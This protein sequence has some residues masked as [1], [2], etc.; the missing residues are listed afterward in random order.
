MPSRQLGIMCASC[1]PWCFPAQVEV[2]DPRWGT[3]RQ[4]GAALGGDPHGGIPILAF[5]VVSRAA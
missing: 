3:F 2:T 4:R 1:C 5:D